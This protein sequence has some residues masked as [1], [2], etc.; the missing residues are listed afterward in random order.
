MAFNESLENGM[1]HPYILYIK[2]ECPKRFLKI[3]ICKDFARERERE[4][5]MLHGFVFT[6]LIEKGKSDSTMKVK[7]DSMFIHI[8]YL[9]T[10]HL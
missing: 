7:S 3:I 5:E 9:W 10:E 2:N 1:H 8:V 4:R 6:S